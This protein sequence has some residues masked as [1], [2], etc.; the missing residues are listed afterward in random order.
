MDSDFYMQSKNLKKKKNDIRR[1]R[2]ERVVSHGNHGVLLVKEHENR[3]E[4]GP[5][6]H[7]AT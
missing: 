1:M 3:T 5:R 7:I 2:G 6:G 4:E